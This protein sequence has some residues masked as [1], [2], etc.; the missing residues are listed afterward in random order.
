MISSSNYIINNSKSLTGNILIPGD[1]SITHRAI[2][3]AALS[4]GITLIKNP[5]LSEDCLNTIK[6]F[7]DLGVDIS[8]NEDIKIVGKGIHG[9]NQPKDIIYAGNSGTLARLLSGILVAQKFSSSIIGDDSLNK[10]P[11][12]RIINPLKAIGGLIESNDDKLPIVFTPSKSLH[13]INYN[14]VIASAQIKSCLIFTALYIGANSIITEEI[15]TRDHTERLLAYLNYPIS[16]NQKKITVKGI[17]PLHAKDI[18]VPSDISSASFFIVAALIKKDSDIVMKNIGVNPLRTGLL[19]V[20]I[21]MGANIKL[22]NKKVVCNEPIADIR[23]RYSTLKPINISGKIVSRMIDELPILFIACAVCN[24]ES[25]IE[26]IEELRYKESDR[27]SSMEEGFRNIGIKASSSKDSIKI[28]GGKFTGGIVDSNDDHRIA[29]AFLIAGL[30]SKKPI[31]VREAQNINT[32]FP[33][34]IDIL[35]DMNV[36]VYEI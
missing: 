27:I 3:I 22:T 6:A 35:R 32:S 34:F 20:L 18:S 13:H 14:N 10:R 7:K 16:N 19:D 2:M 1:K 17:E 9:F 8:I 29:M 12:G 28:Q 26:D 23:V 25:I 4:H 21:D 30:I 33:S 11:M 5:L 15:K 36:E 31:T 24:G